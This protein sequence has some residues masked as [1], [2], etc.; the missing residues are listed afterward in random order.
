MFE[1]R[2]DGEEFL[3]GA[4]DAELSAK[5]YPFMRFVNRF[6]GGRK[7][8]TDFFEG[9][10]N[11]NELKKIR[12]LDIGSGMCDIPAALLRWGEKKGV[13]VEIT[14]LEKNPYA[15][16]MAAQAYWK[17]V[18]RLDLKAAD[19][20]EFEPARPYDYAVGSMFFHHL[21]DGEIRAAI[22]HLRGFVTKA[23]LINDLRRSFWNWTG[24]VVMRPFLDGRVYNDA[25]VSVRRGFELADLAETLVGVKD[26]AVTVKRCGLSRI[27]AV[28]RF[29]QEAV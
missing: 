4:A 2:L 11:V 23:V 7:V 14:C 16:A 17:E 6:L 19:L 8:V 15:L 3:D 12:V 22:E 20:F 25:A 5:S 10:V 29:T 28:I 27:A 26:A 24:C 13:E 18:Q 1:T 9:E 21:T